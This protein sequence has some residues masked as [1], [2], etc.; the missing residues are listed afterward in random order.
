MTKEDFELYAS[1][2]PAT[3]EQVLAMGGMESRSALMGQQMDDPLRYSASP[4]GAGFASLGN[5]LRQGVQGDA[6]RRINEGQ[7]ALGRA[8]PGIGRQHLS[9]Q[10]ALAEALAAATPAAVPAQPMMAP[11]A[12]PSFGLAQLR[13]P[14]A[15][16]LGG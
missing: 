10:K 6:E 14:L 16:L 1:M 7:A 12:G 11:G 15:G 5:V 2:D 4:V 8:I 9:R 3:L 13:N